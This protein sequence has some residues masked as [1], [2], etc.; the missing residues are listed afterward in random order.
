M[1]ASSDKY[2]INADANLFSKLKASYTLHQDDQTYMYDYLTLPFATWNWN[3]RQ[4]E[5][6]I[7][8][9]HDDPEITIEQSLSHSY[10]PMSGMNI[11]TSPPLESRLINRKQII[12]M[13]DIDNRPSLG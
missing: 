11:L 3:V 13:R 8:F 10:D 1:S 5:V 2:D 7:N 12:E 9:G 4:S 6:P